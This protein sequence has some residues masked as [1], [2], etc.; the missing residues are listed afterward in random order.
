MQVL[1]LKNSQICLIVVV[2]INT[3][4][5]YMNTVYKNIEAQMS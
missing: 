3:Q 1:F 5:L 2:R 4:I